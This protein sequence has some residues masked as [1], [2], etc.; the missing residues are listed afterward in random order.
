MKKTESNSTFKENELIGV[1]VSSIY[2]Q[3]LQDEDKFQNRF[4]FVELE[5]GLIFNLLEIR[6]PEPGSPVR[7]S[8]VLFE[9]TF[10]RI[11]I[12]TKDAW[13][14]SP[15]K[16]LIH[17]EKLDSEF[18]VVLENGYVLC[19]GVNEYETFFDFHLPDP[20]DASRFVELELDKGG[21]LDGDSS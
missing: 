1:L 6:Y 20:E 16:S 4:V 9:G 10:E 19:I 5:N 17:S 8:K 7:L 11:A 13:L 15:I 21:E 3:D 14:R 2:Y 18:G 12:A